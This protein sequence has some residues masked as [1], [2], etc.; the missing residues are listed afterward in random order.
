MEPDR[1]SIL[2]KGWIFIELVWLLLLIMCWQTNW[3]RLMSFRLQTKVYCRRFCSFSIARRL[4]RRNLPIKAKVFG[5]IGKLLT[6]MCCVSGTA[7]VLGILIANLTAT[8]CK[9]RTLKKKNFFSFE[10]LSLT[11]GIFRSISFVDPMLVV[12]SRYRSISIVDFRY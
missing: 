12:G 1:L 5:R 4:C 2:M 3:T 6:L 7:T 10:Y 8:K 9:E 11:L